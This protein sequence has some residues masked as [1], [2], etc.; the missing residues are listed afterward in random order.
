MFTLRRVWPCAVVGRRRRFAEHTRADE[1][2]ALIERPQTCRAR[3][4][5]RSLKNPDT[6][7]MCINAGQPFRTTINPF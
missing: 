2:V 4:C 6:E 7:L 1:R 5:T 3:C